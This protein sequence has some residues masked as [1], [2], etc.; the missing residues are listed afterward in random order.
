[1]SSRSVSWNL[2]PIYVSLHPM[3]HASMVGEGAL[4]E[5]PMTFR[6]FHASLLSRLIGV[7]FASHHPSVR[8][9]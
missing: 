7:A 6:A 5:V 9:L 3:L 4:G 8:F 1:M 2:G